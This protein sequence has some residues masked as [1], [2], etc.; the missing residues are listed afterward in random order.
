MLVNKLKTK[1]IPAIIMLIAMA[2]TAIMTFYKRCSV[3]ESLVTILT[4]MIIF[5]ILG[6]IVKM[7]LDRIEIIIKEDTNKDGEVIE[8]NTEDNGKNQDTDDEGQPEIKKTTE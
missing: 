4:V 5:L 2:I 6:Q 1:S 7:I 3:K 8:K